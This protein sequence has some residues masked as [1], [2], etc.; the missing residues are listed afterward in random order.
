MGA[1]LCVADQLSNTINKPTIFAF[2]QG[3]GDKSKSINPC[4]LQLSN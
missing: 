1:K 2:L 3:V 4:S